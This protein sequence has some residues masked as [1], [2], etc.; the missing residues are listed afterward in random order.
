MKYP[1][2]V[3]GVNLDP[4]TNKFTDGDPG[5]P[6]PASTDRAEDMNQVFDELE[7]VIVQGGGAPDY[8]DLTQVRDAIL[9]MIGSYIASPNFTVDPCCRIAQGAVAN[10]STS[11]QYG[12]VDMVQA[13]ATGT[14]VSAGTITQDGVGTAGGK[15]PWSVKVAGATI[16][17]AGKIFFRRF[18]S[19]NEAQ[20]MAGKNCI[21]GAVAFQDTGAPVNGFVTVNYANSANNF[22]AVT[23]IGTSAA[24]PVA[25]NTSTQLK[26][27]VAVPAGASNGI[28]VIIELDVGAIVTKDAYVTDFCAAVGTSIPNFPVPLWAND[29]YGV[30]RYYQRSYEYGTATGA[31]VQNGATLFYIGNAVANGNGMCIYEFRQSMALMPV[32]TAYSKA[33]TSGKVS[34]PGDTAVTV[35]PYSN[36]FYLVNNSGGAITDGAA[37]T[38]HYVADC[39]L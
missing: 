29:F 11:R 25:N 5:V 1:I 26:Y 36:S 3:A 23:A 28:E 20:N 15:T 14:L 7:A 33:G 27:A 16:T 18:Y 39:R 37:V 30:N 22:G 17:G 10:L 13:W 2:G 4:I 38:V 35:T 6:T 34:A 8:N 32:V 12:A 24:Q 9:A 19:Q 21:F 31:A